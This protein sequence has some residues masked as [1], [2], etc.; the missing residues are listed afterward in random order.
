MLMRNTK[1]FV[2]YRYILWIPY[3]YTKIHAKTDVS[4]QIRV[5]F[6]LQDCTN[7][8]RFFPNTTFSFRVICDGSGRGA[9]IRNRK[10]T[11]REILFRI[12]VVHWIKENWI[13]SF[14][15]CCDVIRRAEAQRRVPI[16]LTSVVACVLRRERHS[17]LVA[18]LQNQP[19]VGVGS[20]QST[21]ESRGCS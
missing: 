3:L 17:S 19:R 21:F 4:F 12:I 6:F 7:A 1:I 14:H 11:Q 8:H 13:P 2:S 20:W 18:S 16:A 15:A 10:K 9:R 5:D